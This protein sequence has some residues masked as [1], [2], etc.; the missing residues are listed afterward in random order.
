VKTAAL[1]LSVLTL[2]V[3]GPRRI[4]QGWQTRRAALAERLK[5]E[6]VDAAAFQELWR[7]ADLDA[8]AKAASLA[9]SVSDAPLGL[10]VA[11]RYPL[12]HPVRK[13]LG[14]GGGAL[15][16]QMRL[17]GQTPNLYSVRLTPGDDVLSAARRL[18]Q[19][20]DLS[21]FVRQSTGPFIL[22]GDL[23]GPPDD[24]EIKLFLDLLGARDLCVAHGDEACG[25]T[26]D[27][28]RVDYALI[29]YASRP[30][31]ENARAAFTETHVDDDEVRPLSA[32]FGLTARL[33]AAW[34]KSSPAKDPD[35]RQEALASVADALDSVRNDI[36]TKTNRM[37]WIPWLGTRRILTLRTEIE[38]LVA[39]TERARTALSRAAKPAVASYD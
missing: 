30:P 15:R 21:E 11:S 4:H 36:E 38:R 18:A 1:V 6:K 10:A 32:H 19:L 17:S 3:A 39:A 31:S 16:V 35:G 23:A 22:L 2:N 9:H 13:D 24:P 20:F 29:P 14:W 25:R 5:A 28:K 34:L 8:L 26:L 33:D 37:G 27:D 7:G 12:E